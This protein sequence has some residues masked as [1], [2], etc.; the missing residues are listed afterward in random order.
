MVGQDDG[1]QSNQSEQTGYLEGVKNWLGNR[2]MELDNQNDPRG[3]G[4]DTKRRMFN[5]KNPFGS[6]KTDPNK[7]SEVQAFVEYIEPIESKPS[8]ET[9]MEQ[10]ENDHIKELISKFKYYDNEELTKVIESLVSKL[11]LNGI[12]IDSTELSWLLVK[13]MTDLNA[14]LEFVLEEFQILISNILFF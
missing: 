12:F 13:L 4:G 2:K 10:I 14:D 11:V 1:E 7:V 9:L 3:P 6:S 8:F 5:I